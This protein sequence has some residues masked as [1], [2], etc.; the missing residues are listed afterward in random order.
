[1][2]VGH[3]RPGL[4]LGTLAFRENYLKENALLMIKSLPVILMVSVVSIPLFAETSMF[5]PADDKRLE[6]SDYANIEFIANPDKPNRAIARMSRPLNSPWKGYNWDNPGARLRFRTN[7]KDVTA[8]LIF[9]DK[10]IS[11]SARN[12]NGVYRIDGKSSPD[13]TLRSRDRKTKR[14]VE[15][16]DLRLPVPKDGAF[17]D[18]E[19]IM[20]YGDAI[21]V[22]G[23][24]VSDGAEFQTPTPRPKRRCAIYGDS[25]TQGFTASS[26]D[27]TYAFRLAELKKH[28]LVNLGIGGRSSRASDGNVVGKIPCDQLVVLMGVN[29]WQGGKPLDTYKKNM[30]EFIVNFRKHQKDTPICFV[31]P[32]W[33]PP[34][35]RPKRVTNPLEAYRQVL[36]DVVKNAADPNITLVEGPELIDHDPKLFDRVAVHP[37]DAGFNMM[38]QRLAKHLPPQ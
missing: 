4:G 12:A 35:W 16:L 3:T 33:V 27:Q 32:L 38:A 5:V 14:E 13:W 31:T 11:N 36:R 22:A 34:A 9:S 8:R 6:Y 19:I 29:D 15:N 24:S 30:S 17:H 25:V 37:N 1:M 2:D 23:V 21:D 20:P 26:V 18:Y 10:H 28:Q 7:A